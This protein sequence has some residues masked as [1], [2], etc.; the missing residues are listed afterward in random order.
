MTLQHDGA[1]SNTATL[2]QEWSDEKMAGFWTKDLLPPSSPDL[3]PMDF[4]VWSIQESNACLSYHPS[5]TSV[6]AKLKH[7]WVNISTET[8][9]ASCNQ[10][11][12]RMK[13]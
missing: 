1:T 9:C 7:C 8:I 5:V 10:V 12:V 6:E 3:H 2:V 13:M 11:T 4:A